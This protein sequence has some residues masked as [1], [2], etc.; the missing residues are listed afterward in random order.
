VF[1]WV[2][3]DFWALTRIPDVADLL[4]SQI[5][6]GYSQ[7]PHIWTHVVPAMVGSAG[8]V[9]HFDGPAEGRASVWIALTDAT[10]TNGCMHVVPRPHLA[11]SFRADSLET[12]QVALIDALRALHR[13]R[14]L[15]VPRGTALGWTFDVLHWGGA[16][17]DV[18]SARRAVSLEFIAADRAP[19]ADE[20]P[21]I[22]LSGDFPPLPDRLRMI[23]TAVAGYEKFEP[24]LVRHRAVA[25]RLLSF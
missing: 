3:D 7:I 11:D 4:A 6:E 23:A 1:A 17:L 18:Q 19:N 15:P 12:A 14:A 22:P 10:L 13:V 25:K 20:S 16:C 21:V 8:W 24:G 2:Y 9:P 5:G